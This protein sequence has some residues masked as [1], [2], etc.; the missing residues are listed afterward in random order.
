MVDKDGG[1]GDDRLPGAG[2][3]AEPGKPKLHVP[4]PRAG[5]PTAHGQR[6]SQSAGSPA[7]PARARLTVPA[8]PAADDE[9]TAGD[10]RPA[11]DDRTAAKA[12]TSQPATTGKRGGTRRPRPGPA[13]R[14]LMETIAASRKARQQR[15]LIAAFGSMS[16]LVMLVAG[17]TWVL[18]SYVS[19][20]LARINAG[21]TGTPAS[22]PVNILVAGVDVRSGLTRHQQLELHVG[23]AVSANS[24]TMMLV[25]I[26]AD[27]SSVD[28]VSLPRDSWVAIPGHSMN[29]INAA[30]GIGGPPLMVRTVE[31]ATGLKLND[32]IEVNFLG[33]VRVVNALGGVNICLPFAV[34]DPDSG[35]H[36]SAGVH[37]VG[38]V[39]AL[40][41]AR[42]RHSFGLSDFARISDQQQLLASMFEEIVSAGTLTN[43]FKLQHVLSAVSSAVKVDEGFNLNRL[44]SELRGIRPSDVTFRTVPLA[45]TNYTTPTGESAV[46]WDSAKARTLFMHLGD[47]PPPTQRRH[48]T[49]PARGSVDVN[50]YNGTTISKL[51]SRTGGQL[52]ALGFTVVKDGVNWHS[53]LS[54]TLIEYPRGKE[55]A[56]R[57]VLRILPGAHLQLSPTAH[58]VL[59]LLGST[60]HQLSAKAR[61]ELRSSAAVQPGE[62]V[63]SGQRR[64]AAQDACH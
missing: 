51:S 32:Y 1:P 59:V 57:L 31:Q 35:L 53:K 4:R 5:Q 49:G 45:N 40:E 6:S 12:H 52:A 30:Y 26:P 2:D 46:L 36:L 24:D 58:S 38:G 15:A 62:S 63:V 55:A 3:G 29:K 61:T 44:V 14:Q 21:T 8:A 22:G 28:V 37:H 19:H 54:G 10:D 60:G 27:H 47:L 50:V 18:T 20:N 48:R 17:S 43:P 64:T 25:H 41:F 56:A 9:R 11:A 34:H 39:T 16:L 7:A 33:F 13:Q 42:D 23:Q